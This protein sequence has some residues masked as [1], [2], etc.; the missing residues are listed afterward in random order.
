MSLN[1]HVLGRSVHH[2]A[3][4]AKASKRKVLHGSVKHLPEEWTHSGSTPD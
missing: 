1:E 3:E 4:T 2:M